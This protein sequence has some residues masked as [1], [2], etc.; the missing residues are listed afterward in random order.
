VDAVGWPVEFDQVGV[1]FGVRGADDGSVKVSI[2]LVNTGHR[3][4]DQRM[5]V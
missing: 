3:Y 5:R 1:E 4:L 2:A